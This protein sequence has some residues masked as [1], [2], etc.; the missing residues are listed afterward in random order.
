MVAWSLLFCFF[1]PSSQAIKNP[2]ATLRYFLQ[3]LGKQEDNPHVAL[4]RRRFPEHELG[5]DPQ[6]QTVHFQISP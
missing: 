2:K 4:Y 1:S 3:L 5:V 6:R